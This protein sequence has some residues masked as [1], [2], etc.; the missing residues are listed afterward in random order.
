MTSHHL[1]ALALIVIP[2]TGTPTH[3]TAMAPS[4]H[5]VYMQSGRGHLDSRVLR[6]AGRPWSLAWRFTCGS[7]QPHVGVI[8]VD[9]L[10]GVP[11]VRDELVVHVQGGQTRS[12]SR[13]PPM[14]GMHLVDAWGH[15]GV[16]FEPLV[17]GSYTL[18]IT[19]DCA[20]RIRVTAP[21]GSI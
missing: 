8:K 9:A 18:S 7:Q 3:V 5:T 1:A 12:V 20:W 17:A 10:Y 19:T 16:R 13:S 21:P 15:A 14:H 4:L 11:S 6:I 2:T